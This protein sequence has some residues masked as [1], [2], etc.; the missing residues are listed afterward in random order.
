MERERE[1]ERERTKERERDTP[2]TAATAGPI[3]RSRRSCNRRQRNG[4]WAGRITDCVGL[5][6]HGPAPAAAAYGA[7][8]GNM[9]R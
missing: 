5:R 2:R 9:P 1:N 3:R 6:S 7:V 4:A 8:A